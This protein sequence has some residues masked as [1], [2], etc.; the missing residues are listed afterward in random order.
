[1]SRG[2]IGPDRAPFIALVDKAARA[3]RADMVNQVHD[4][5]YPE[6]TSAHNAVFAT[7]PSEG[8]RA[9]DMA[10]RAGITRQSMGEVIR[11]MV[12]LG[13]LEMNPDPDD[14]R[15]KVVGWTELGREVAQG[16]KAYMVELE[17]QFIAEF[18]EA[19]YETARRV[20]ERVR[21]MLEADG[22][23]PV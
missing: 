22:P 1:M 16:G 12:S 5:G 17:K 4:R 23:A 14:R 10:T 19:D 15:A 18:G 7:L 6:I 21:E 2:F 13:F 9:A 3:M 20:L 11:D 8:A